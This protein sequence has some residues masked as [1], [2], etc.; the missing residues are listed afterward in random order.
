MLR[1]ENRL[2]KRK[3]FGYI[4]KHGE[5][6]YTKNL[7]LMHTVN[8]FKKIKVGF[9]ISKKVGKAFVRNLVKRRLRAIVREHMGE[10]V[11]AKNYVLIAKPTVAD[12]SY[13]ELEKEV[14]QIF[15]KVKDNRNV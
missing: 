14:L 10:F 8:K 12:I 7:V 15:A 9:S 6:L 11:P 2:K 13:Q 3:E 4:Y 1:N 5:S